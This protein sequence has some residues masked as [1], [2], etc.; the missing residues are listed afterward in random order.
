MKLKSKNSGFTL[1]ELLVVIAVLSL[2]ASISVT[3]YNPLRQKAR[4]SRRIQDLHQ[5]RNA[6]N[7]YML[8][9]GDYPQGG[10]NPSGECNGGWDS[11]SDGDFIPELRA[12]GLIAKDLLDPSIN[13]NNGNCGNYQY[14]HFDAGDWGCDPA[15]GR[16]Y[17]LQVIDM[18]ST[19]S[20]PGAGGPPFPTSPGFSC[21]GQDFSHVWAEYVIGEFE[22]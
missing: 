1:I 4:D 18:E 3:S 21:P 22:N 15:R 5:L 11:S 19:P 6:L 12:E 8:N 17:V 20:F 10:T 7:L 13:N 16:Y 2:L 9:H 14:A